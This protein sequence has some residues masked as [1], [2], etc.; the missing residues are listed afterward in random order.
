MQNA[1]CVYMLQWE[2][3][4]TIQFHTQIQADLYVSVY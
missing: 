4:G 2:Q 1:V 3:E